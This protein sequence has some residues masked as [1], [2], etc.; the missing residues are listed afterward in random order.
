MS[1]A[2]RC[3]HPY[4]IRSPV[5][6]GSWF[7]RC[8]GGR[9]GLRRPVGACQCPGR[10]DAGEAGSRRRPD[11]A[12]QPRLPAPVPGSGP[13]SSP[14]TPTSEAGAHPGAGRADGAHPPGPKFP[15]LGRI[16]P[17]HILIF[18]YSAVPTV[19]RE[20][21]RSTMRT[22][23]WLV[24]ARGSVATTSIVGALALRA[25]LAGPTGCVTELPELRGPALP[26]FADLVF[27]GHDVATT[28]LCKRPRRSPTPVSSPAGWSPRSATSWPRSSRSCA[29]HRSAAPRPTGPP[30]W[31]ATSPASATG[32]SWTGWWWSTSPPPSRPPDRTRRTPTR[33]RCAPRSP[34]PDEVLP[35][36][37]LYAYA[38]LHRRLPVRRLHP[39]HRA[40]AA[41]AGRAG[42]GGRPA[43][44]RARRQDRGDAGQVGARADV[45]DAQPGRALLVRGQPARRRRRRHPRR[46]GRQRG[47]GAAASS[48]CSARRWATSPQGDTRIEYVEELGDFKTAWDLITFAGFLGTGMRMEFTWH[49]CD[50]ALAA[51]LVLDLARLTAAA[52][53]A[54]QAGPL[55]DLAFFFKDPLGAPH[56]LAGRAVGPADRLRPATDDG[57]DGDR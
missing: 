11:P 4:R 39:V 54:G 29:R 35:P 41:R 13:A 40:A 26:A 3:A 34:A 56:P 57:R 51:P 47:Q 10:P 17:K 28:P 24:G 19:P 55:T 43:V 2:R 30:P 46:P 9:G 31:S 6:G 20:R 48:G 18:L 49:G 33:P 1:T 53:A 21:G 15:K 5:P 38:A 37:S 44:R 16:F 50:S 42:R 23:V 7:G 36:S 8:S 25:G 27:G 22:G 12:Y 32:T 14:P 45:R 52:H